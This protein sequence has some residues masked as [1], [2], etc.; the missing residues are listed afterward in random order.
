VEAID[1]MLQTLFKATA[2][3]STGVAGPAGA[4][5]AT[6]AAGAPGAAGSGGASA[7]LMGPPG[8]DGRDGDDATWLMVGMGGLSP[9]TRIPTIDVGDLLVG[10]AKNV[11][12]ALP[13][14]AVG[15]ALVSGGV[16]TAPAWSATPTLG[17]L[18]LSGT[19]GASLVSNGDFATNLTGWSGANWAW[20]GTAPALGAK[21]TTGST[22]ALTQAGA[23]VVAGTRYRL[24][25]AIKGRNTGTVTP[26]VGGA[27]FAATS[28]A[29]NT[30]NF[31]A[32]ATTALAFTPSTNFD[33][34][35]DDVVLV[36]VTGGTLAAD[37]RMSVLGKVL[38]GT[39][40]P[41]VADDYVLMLSTSSPGAAD[42]LRLVAPDQASIAF[43]PFETANSAHI[44]GY[45][46]SGANT[47]LGFV[48]H[49]LT[50]MTINPEGPIGINYSPVTDV[51]AVGGKSG[52]I[53]QRITGFGGGNG[54]N[55]GLNIDCGVGASDWAL[56][57][58]NQSGSTELLKVR[59]DGA[60]VMSPAVLL[61]LDSTG[62]ATFFSAVLSDH[63][64]VGHY[65]FAVGQ[66]SNPG[67]ASRA[68][69]VLTIG[70][71]TTPL[72]GRANTAEPAFEWRIED[73]YA[74]GGGSPGPYVEAHWAYYDAAGGSMRPIA[75]QIDRTNG[76]Y[77]TNCAMTFQAS[78]WS[79]LGT[80]GTQYVKFSA[81]ALAL[82][83]STILDIT[84]NNYQA[85]R[86]SNA[87][88]S[89][90]ISLGYI[91]SGNFHR[92]G[93]GS[94]GVVV[95][96]SLFVGST[97]APKWTNFADQGLTLL[98]SAGAGAYLV[99]TN[100]STPG[101]APADTFKFYGK[102]TG[103]GKMQVVALFPT[104]AEQII[105]TEP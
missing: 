94:S 20:S 25:F 19:A 62:N 52:V 82:F 16:A 99:M 89:G 30:L 93:V 37:G 73:Y 1:E 17:G 92:I 64:A 65:N 40:V 59:G 50:R 91:D 68:D 86:Q 49:D 77:L 2:S 104:G 4:T 48:T 81:A 44:L 61:P 12:V 55:L 34:A 43:S 7:G 76:G 41:T 67:D 84:V 22:V 72:G 15:S 13:D 105:A 58:R 27:T 54:T 23:T 36:A 75:L 6:G 100:Q 102:K 63:G 51:F 21:H 60:I 18:T 31:Y 87:A 28:S 42:V 8:L 74:P 46:A 9:S 26:S 29:T 35:V 90:F 103:G 88:G 101:A 53:T 66:T 95:S 71:N 11:L 10:S 69:H 98:T 32:T 39:D 56:R 83:N 80:D 14:V 5:G 3:L 33:G 45:S 78:S 38:M 85:V 24:T 70:Y 47:G 79:Y 57:V 97:T 96:G